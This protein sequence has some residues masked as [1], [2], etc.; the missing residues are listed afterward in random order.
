MRLDSSSVRKQAG[1]E[2]E[3]DCRGMRRKTP[4]ANACV[5]FTSI[6]FVFSVN[7]N[8]VACEGVKEDCEKAKNELKIKKIARFV[9]IKAK[10]RT[11]MRL[12]SK[13]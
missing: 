4:Q 8:N 3:N 9:L 2:K 12:N 11:T 6:K 1:E 7:K 10:R 5:A 13:L